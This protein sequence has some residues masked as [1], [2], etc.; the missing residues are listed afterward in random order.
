[1]WSS[2]CQVCK[3]CHDHDGDDHS[4]A[5]ESDVWGVVHIW[6]SGWLDLSQRSLQTV[7]KALSFSRRPLNGIRK[8]KVLAK[9]G[10]LCHFLIGSAGQRLDCW[11]ELARYVAI[12]RLVS[13]ETDDRYLQEKWSMHVR[14]LLV[15]ILAVAGFLALAA[16]VSNALIEH[17][18]SLSWLPFD[19]W[20]LLIHS[21]LPL[22]EKSMHASWEW[23]A[24]LV[25]YFYESRMLVRLSFTC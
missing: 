12:L 13:N 6:R 7:T 1:M 11:Q 24:V 5:K 17:I 23:L 4:A 14:F 19:S 9:G 3:S 22:C 15:S 25:M 16:V 2:V 10:F 21:S 18:W 8:E 20:Y